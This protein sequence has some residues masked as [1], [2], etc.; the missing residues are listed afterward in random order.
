VVREFGAVEGGRQTLERLG[1]FLAGK[2]CEPFVISRE[3][4]APRDLVWKTWTER[5]RLMEWFGPKGFTRLTA[6]LD[7]RPGGIFH[8]ALRA[9]DGR[10]MW[11]KFVYREIVPPKKIV[12]ANSFSDKDGGITRHPFSS[13]P[14][15]LQMLTEATF[16]ER[17]G[18]TT[19]TIKWLPLDSTEEERKVF[20]S[21][22][23]SMNQGW[24]GT[25]EQLADY[26]TKIKL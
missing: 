11:G 24:T 17:D 23:A 8:Y 16:T 1:E 6:K 7:F 25:F 18:K 20:D 2:L 4:P 12:W 13:A 14:W 21:M 9:P 10:E 22:H 5:E 19:V 26:L 3:F 15:P